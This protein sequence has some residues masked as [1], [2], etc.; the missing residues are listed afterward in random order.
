MSVAMVPVHPATRWPSAA[1]RAAI[2]WRYRAH[3]S[4][5]PAS[6]PMVTAAG[7]TGTIATDIPA[8]A[9]LSSSAA[10]EVAS[11]LVALAAGGGT[12]DPSLLPVVADIGTRVENELLGLPS[13]IMDQLISATAPADGA[14]LIDCR[15]HKSVAV[16]IPDEAVVVVLDTGT[17]RQLVDSQFAARRADCER[18]ARLL[19]R[20]SL[21]DAA[22]E[23]LDR[24]A[25]H[26]EADEVVVARARHVLTEN[27]RTER[28][29]A[30]LAAGDLDL[31]GRLMAESHR[32]LADDY[33]VSSPAIEAMVDVASAA[34]GCHGARVTGG[35]FAGCAVALVAAAQVPAFDEHVRA[36]FRAPVDQPA[37]EPTAL[38]P[39]RPAAGAS[40]TIG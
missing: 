30:A 3:P 23:D 1:S 5:P 11:G 28:A 37:T 16:P 29:A 9:G 15:H 2:P 12:P 34:P 36:R 33:E 21:R 31:V 20:D 22:M 25:A 4:V 19:D 24:L 13:G 39:V 38:Y 32:S 10:L 6:S 18:A 40:I 8:G 26:P 14:L 35:G 17:R 7:W 27:D